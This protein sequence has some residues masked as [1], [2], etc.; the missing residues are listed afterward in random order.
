MVIVFNGA[1]EPVCRRMFEELVRLSTAGQRPHVTYS[2]GLDRVH[3]LLVS[4]PVASRPLNPALPVRRP[5]PS[6]GALL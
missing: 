5:R 1:K 3:H 6:D 2:I 4:C